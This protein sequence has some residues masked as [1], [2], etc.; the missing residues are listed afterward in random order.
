SVANISVMGKAAR[1][2]YEEQYI[3]GYVRNSSL[4]TLSNIDVTLTVSGAN[5]FTDTYKILNISAG[6]TATVPFTYSPTAQGNTSITI[7]IPIDQNN[8]N[9]SFV[10][11]QS[12]TCNVLAHNPPTGSY[13]SAL[14][15]PAT[16]NVEGAY[17]VS[18]F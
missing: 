9:N 10:R 2:S 1:N 16:A 17:W 12:V 3:E 14:G 8:A 18:P 13:T 4:G 7:S 15:F 11:T 6:Q 5:T